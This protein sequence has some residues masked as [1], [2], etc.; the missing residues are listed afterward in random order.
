MILEKSF[1]AGNY[2]NK[3]NMITIPFNSIEY[4]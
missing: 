1:N 3:L 4:A 2:Y